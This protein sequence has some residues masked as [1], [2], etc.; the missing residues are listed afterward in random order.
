MIAAREPAARPAPVSTTKVITVTR[1]DRAAIAVLLA[2][3]AAN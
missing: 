2:A 1:F 3:R